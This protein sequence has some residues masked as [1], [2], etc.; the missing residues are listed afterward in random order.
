[1]NIFF[2]KIACTILAFLCSPVFA[3]Q[4]FSAQNAIETALKNN[5]SIQS[6]S[7]QIEQQR[8][9]A[10]GYRDFGKTNFGF[11]YGQD[12]GL[13]WDNTFSI[14]QP[15][16]N[17][18]L[19]KN[20]KAYAEANTKG[21]ELNL[22]VTK[23]ELE[24][25][26]KTAYYQ[27]SYYEALRKLLQKQ[28]TLYSGFLKA[29]DLR[30]QTGE[31]NLLEKATAETQLNEIRNRL[32]Q[33]E[34]NIEIVNQQLEGFL[35]S[36]L[37]ANVEIDTLSKISTLPKINNS[38]HSANP[39]AMYVQQQVNIAD[40]AI[41]LE[42]A[43]RKP[44]FSVG[45]YN[46]SIIGTQQVNGQEKT[47]GA[48]YRFQVFS[49]GLAIPILG[50]SYSSRIKAAVTEKQIAKSQ[51]DLFKINLQSQ[52]Q[53]ALKEYL[54]NKKSIEYFE[55]SAL[56]NANLI[57]RQAQ[58]A[59]QSGDIGYVEYLQALRTHTGIHVE[60]LDAINQL[61]QSILRI[62]YLTGM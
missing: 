48:G 9:L 52:Y 33:N 21:S 36:P 32:Q 27:L 42:K 49:V 30:Y 20:Q 34:A 23:N 44:D 16:P 58:L 26:V 8:I 45:Y 3:Q 5:P 12:N 54:K 28:D 39:R 40:K 60:Y 55:N 10:T 57:L 22:A 31:T 15:I 25:Q 4:P 29:A 61:N 51:Y 11:Q 37:P 59:F 13:K 50:R 2:R 7:L 14:E 62:Q 17:P 6:A 41:S 18:A 1:M 38:I 43:K 35:N 56:A 47:F 46:H 19:F 53:Q 24:Y